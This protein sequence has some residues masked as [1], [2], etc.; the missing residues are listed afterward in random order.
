MNPKVVYSSSS[1]SRI[2]EEITSGSDERRGVGDSCEED[3]NIPSDSN[4][5]IK[6]KLP[7]LAENYRESRNF[8]ES[9]Q[10]H[11]QSSY[12]IQQHHVQQ[13]HVQQYPVQEHHVQQQPVQQQPVQQHHVQ[14]QLVQQPVQQQPVQQNP[15][16]QHPVQQHHVQQPV[17]QQ[18]VQHQ[19]N[20]NR[21]HPRIASAENEP[22]IFLNQ[23]FAQSRLHFIGSWRNRLPTMVNR[24]MKK[25]KKENQIQET[26]IESTREARVV[27]GKEGEG[28]G[29]GERG[30]I[31][32]NWSSKKKVGENSSFERDLR[33][34]VKSNLEDDEEDGEDAMR[35]IYAFNSN[36]SSHN[37]LDLMNGSNAFTANASNSINNNDNTI[38]SS[39]SPTLSVGKFSKNQMTSTPSKHLHLTRIVIHLDMDCFFVSAV[40]RSEAMKYLRD[41]PVAVAHSADTPYVVSSIPSNINISTSSLTVQP[42]NPSSSSSSSSSSFSSSSSSAI[43]SSSPYPATYSISSPS[44]LKQTGDQAIPTEKN[45][46]SN[47]LPPSSSISPPRPPPTSTSFSSSSEI[48]SCNYPARM[49]GRYHSLP[50][51]LVF[52]DYIF[53]LSL[54]NLL[55]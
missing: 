41:Q 19:P 9:H 43:S 28:E 30:D 12:S 26:G 14:Q 10:A 34:D 55:I 20:L 40:L 15:M 42:H 5:Y 50:D 33:F 6:E 21:P 27:K 37:H 39:I 32:N 38:D 22:E 8:S 3:S 7:N 31:S 18:P 45:L 36:R 54:P 2:S 35:D 47:S 44:R 24:L 13:H 16:Q 17:Q 49:S 51:G 23:Y 1:C 29:E 25:K 52:I 46:T 4:N 48:S 11:Q 53:L